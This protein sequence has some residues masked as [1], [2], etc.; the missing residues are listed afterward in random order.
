MNDL[1][2]IFE[3]LDKKRKPVQRLFDYYDGR[4]PLQYTAQRL[5]NVFDNRCARFTQNW[6]AVVVDSVLDRIELTGWDSEDRRQNE[7]LDRLWNDLQIDLESFEVHEACAVAGESF[8]IAERTAEGEIKVYAND[9]RNMVMVYED[10]NPHRKRVAGKIFQDGEITRLILYYDDRIEAYIANSKLPD[11]GAFT[12]F[13]YDEENSGS[14]E[15][16]VMPVFHFRNSR[17]TVKSEL[18]NVIPLQDAVNK[19]L[20]DM[21][22]TA[23][24]S[25]FPAR[26]IVTNAE[27]EKLK[28]SPNEVWRIPAGTSDEEGTQIGTLPAADLGNYSSQ[29]SELATSIAVITRTPKHYFYGSTAQPSGEA[30]L[31]MEAPLNKKANK[32]RQQFNPVWAEVGAYLLYLSGF[33]DVPVSEITPVWSPVESIQPKTQAEIRTE[34]IKSG[35]ALTTALRLEGRSADEIGQMMH[36]KQEAQEQE[37]SVGDAVLNSVL[38]RT[39]QI[40]PNQG[41]VPNG[42]KLGK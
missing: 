34:N 6:C 35:L 22:V 31:A 38:A 9:P 4:Q 16:G 1:Q 23:E 42:E 24:F 20:S 39:A 28:N 11:V 32:L 13:R 37:T 29:I 12:A 2:V 36:E 26:Y 21:M 3:A 17:R 27:I 7:E 40:N 14:N 8:L 33:G 19:L 15:S 10:S 30:L 25:A 41:T 5:A 18:A